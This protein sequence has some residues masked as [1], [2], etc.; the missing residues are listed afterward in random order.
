MRATLLRTWSLLCAFFAPEVRAQDSGSTPAQM[1]PVAPAAPPIATPSAPSATPALSPAP[2]STAE[3][4]ASF[5]TIVRLTPL[6]VARGSR[7]VIVAAGLLEGMTRS[8]DRLVGGAA[9]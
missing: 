8:N 2:A 3:L 9:L 4:L 7:V 6:E 1:P 5:P